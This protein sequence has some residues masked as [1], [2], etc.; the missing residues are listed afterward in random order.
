MLIALFLKFAFLPTEKNSFQFYV[1]DFYVARIYF[2]IT[3]N[4]IQ[5]LFAD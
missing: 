5:A 4:E 3:D 2:I 1:L